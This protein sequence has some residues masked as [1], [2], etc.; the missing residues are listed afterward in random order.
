MARTQPSDLAITLTFLRQGQGW[1]QTDL[2]EAA[3]TTSNVVNDYEAGRKP[4]R[5]ERLE[6]LA[7]SMGVPPERIDETLSC[8]EGNRAA[9]RSPHSPSSTARRRIESI[10]AQAA[11]MAADFVRSL[12]LLLT[13]EGE[14]LHERQRADFLWRKLL[15][16]T[17]AQRLMLVEDAG[18]YRSW[19][20]CERVCFASIEAAPNHPREALALAELAVHIAKLAPGEAASRRN[21]EGYALV[22]LSNAWRVCN[23]LHAMETTIARALKL[24]D[25][26]DLGL[27]NPAVVPW[28]EAAVRKDQRKLK[29]ALRKV[30]EALALDSGELRGKMLLTKAFILDAAG[31]SELSA[32]AL[33]EATPLID[34]KKEARL[35]LSLEHNLLWVLCRLGRAEEAA[36]RLYKVRQLAE[37]LGQKLDLARVVWLGGL[38]DAGLRH[39]EKAE[40][41]FRQVRR[42]IEVHGLPYDYALVSLDLSLALLEQGR[43]GEVRTVAEEMLTIFQRL[44]I[45]REAMMAIQVFCEAAKREAATI[46]LAQRVT[47]FLLRAQSDPDLKFD[48]I[49][50]AGAG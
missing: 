43:N 45:D 31:D 20:L 23:D 8:L 36:P 49:E 17:P 39:S 11:R 28:I 27:L 18:E 3:G 13:R 30:E 21:L 40:A 2:A 46:E 37:K 42:E 22:H 35:A 19:A 41:A 50:E 9:S 4:L 26:G 29:E 38:I 48:D 16:R 33:Y 1:S 6:H 44:K 15:R 14:A 25:E 34:E 47:R 24:W 5:R 12:L 7:S 10:A 32:A